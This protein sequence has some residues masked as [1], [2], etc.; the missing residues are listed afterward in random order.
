V[1]KDSITVSLKITDNGGGIGAVNVYLNGAQVA[2][3]ARGLM[4]KGKESSKEK[5]LSFTIPLIEGQNE[6]KAVAF[7]KENS[8]ESNPALVS[9]VSN[10]VLQKPNLYALV[11]GI[12]TYKNQSIALTYAVPDAIA[13][14]KTL[15]QSASPLFEKTDIQVLT[16]PDVTTKEAITNALE[17]L[18]R[19]IKPN[20][21]FV[22]YNA[23]HGI[24]DVVDGEEQYFL[25]TSNVLLLSSRN[26]GKDAMSQKEL[27]KLVGNIPAQKKLIILD[28]C[29]AG[30]GGKEIQIALLQQTRGLNESTAVKLLQ[31]AI[32]S[33]VF[34]ASS[35]TQQALE[36][37]K[38]HGLFTYVLMEGLQGKADLK[39][40][41][42]ITIYGLADYVGEEVVKLSEEIFKRQQT[43]TVQTSADFPIGR[44]K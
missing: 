6:I 14:G 40:D 44:I 11:V 23:S 41:G 42:F 10:A 39:K 21:L 13:F 12:N 17:A 26:I 30:K 28:T 37:Y 36:G 15:Q 34:S 19:K 4:I 20:D 1:N 33:A 8:M 25:L 35:D 2:N 29:N 18:R 7:N 43:P 9:I 32:G 5:I 27:A 3:D 38:G 31:R 22:F 24:V 16:T